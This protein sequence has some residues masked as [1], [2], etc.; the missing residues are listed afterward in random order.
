MKLFPSKSTIFLLL[1]GSLSSSVFS[2]PAH[3][4]EVSSFP[5]GFRPIH[6]Q[7]DAIAIRKPKFLGQNRTHELRDGVKNPNHYRPIGQRVEHQEV[8][9]RDHYNPIRRRVEHQD[10]NW[11]FRR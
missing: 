11:G 5:D 4:N 2:L 6:H 7:E 8:K 9:N 10:G 1:L 3:A